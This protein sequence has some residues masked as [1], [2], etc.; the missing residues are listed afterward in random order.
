MLNV[1][2]FIDFA[3]PL[4]SLRCPLCPQNLIYTQ[5]IYLKG[6]SDCPVTIFWGFVVGCF[7]DLRNK[8]KGLF[9]LAKSVFDNKKL[10]CT[11]M[12][13]NGFSFCFFQ[14]SF[15][16]FFQR[17]FQGPLPQFLKKRSLF[18]FNA[19]WGQAKRLIKGVSAQLENERGRWVLWIPI[20]LSCGI[21]L[22]FALSNE[23]SWKTVAFS[24]FPLLTL[25][26]FFIF[27]DSPLL[28]FF[29]WALLWGV[30]GFNLIFIRTHLINPHPLALP[31]EPLWITGKVLTIDHPASTQRLFQR[32]VLKIHNK[33][34]PHLPP[35]LPKA[36]LLTIRTSCP[37]L[38]EG[39]VLRLKA[40]LQPFAGPCFPGGY[41]RQRQTFFQGIGATGFAVSC[42]RVLHSH[43]S[44]IS[45]WRHTLTRQLHEQLAPP[46][47]SVACGLVTGDK[48]ALPESTRRAFSDSGLA[49]LLAIAGLHVS[50]LTGLCFFVFQRALAHI[51]RLALYVNLN[52]ISALLSLGVGWFYLMISGQRLPAQRAFFMMA[53]TMV[54]MLIARRKQSMRILLLCALIFLLVQPESL[55]S[56][57]YQL[58]F[59]AVAGLIGFYEAKF[60][61]KKPFRARFRPSRWS[62]VQHFITD[63][64]T[65]TGIITL[66]TLPVMAFHFYHISL[67]GFLSNLIAIPFT[68][69][70]VMP[71]G[72]VTLL[73]LL[74]PWSDPFFIV[75]GWSLQGLVEIAHFSATYF[76][77]LIFPAPPVSSLLFSIQLLGLFWLLLWQNRW[78]WAGLGVVIGA[79]VVG[80]TTH[81]KPSI[82]VDSSHNL[83]GYI[84]HENKALWVSS[85]R[86]GRYCQQR[87]LEAFGLKHILKL[88]D[89]AMFTLISGKTIAIEGGSPMR[90]QADF[91][92]KKKGGHTLHRSLALE[93]LL[94]LTSYA[95]FG[96]GDEVRS[97]YEN[98][99]WH[100]RALPN[101]LE[102]PLEKKP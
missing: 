60:A 83:V 74:T 7:G 33:N 23:P 44:K 52:G 87:W 71:L 14:R 96:A 2:E 47:G 65:S 67:Q 16:R 69:F 13:N 85:L 57:S 55:I 101:T 11:K 32:V 95:V 62:K 39:D 100:P 28:R 9:F 70:V 93:S 58:S 76:T 54:A 77:W 25:S 89:P 72:L 51:P 22:Y 81:I 86:K 48:L 43:P 36:V 41:D 91:V 20:A 90:K 68:A 63:S 37:A 53:A 84:D 82:L 3:V 99:P 50:I 1:R 5:Q 75:W 94:P 46:L 8:A 24:S 61:R 40:S 35:H 73:S 92:L 34:S 66:A 19:L 30:I 64:L 4:I 6:T 49:H 27:Q 97:S 29:S 59:T 18:Y 80:W 31:L 45:Y 12:W 102:N 38:H 17:S 56:L 78:R 98:R 15:Q 10:M 42:P 88:P 26:G 79:I 21:A